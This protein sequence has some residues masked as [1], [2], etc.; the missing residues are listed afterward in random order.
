M[1]RY[2]LSLLVLMFALNIFAQDFHTWLI[3]MLRMN[4]KKLKRLMP[5]W[6]VVA[7]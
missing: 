1:K 2:S 5:L 4:H 6:N 3:L 7:T